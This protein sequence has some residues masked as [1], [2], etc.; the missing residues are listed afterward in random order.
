M[1]KWNREN[2]QGS[3]NTLYDSK[4]WMHIIT[5]LSK[6]IKRATPV[7]SPDINYDLRVITMHHCRFIHCNKCIPRM[8]GDVGNG[9]VCAC[10]GQGVLSETSVLFSQFEHKTALKSILKERKRTKEE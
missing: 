7:M 10:V 2:F 4:R 3:E 9:G 5:H 8:D 1:N 6:S